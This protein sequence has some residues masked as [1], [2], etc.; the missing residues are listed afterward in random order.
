MICA[1]WIDTMFVRNDFPK[2]EKYSDIT[3]INFIQDDLLSNQFDFHID[4][5]EDEQ[6][7]AFFFFICI[8]EEKKDI[9][10]NQSITRN[11]NYYSQCICK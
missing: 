7:H 8:E 1:R 6:F 3:I 9:D 2:L 10:N 4:Q 11:I 5:L